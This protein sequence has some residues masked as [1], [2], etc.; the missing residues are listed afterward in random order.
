[1]ER[2]RTTGFLL[3]VVGLACLMAAGPSVAAQT[4]RTPTAVVPGTAPSAA[5]PTALTAQTSTAPQDP[6]AVSPTVVPEVTPAPALAAGESSAC[7]PLA[8]AW[9]AQLT[10]STETL[11][12]TFKF[13]PSNAEC[14]KFVVNAQAVTLSAKAIKMWPEATDLT[15][16]VGTAG[17]ASTWNDLQFTAIGYGVSRGEMGDKVVFIALLTGRIEV[18]QGC[19]PYSGQDAN[20]VTGGSSNELKMT[21]SVSYFD[22]EQDQDRDGFPDC[23]CSEAVLCVCYEAKLK[24][25]QQLEPCTASQSFFACLEKCQDVNS[26]AQG[27]AFVRILEKEQKICFLVTG[28][29]LQ[30][31]TKVVLQ[32]EG[33]DVVILLPFPPQTT[34]KEGPCEGL[35]CSGC[36]SV[37]DCAGTWKSKKFAEIEKAIQEGK[38][39]IRVVTKNC[40][41]GELCGQLGD[42]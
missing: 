35:L 40:P 6:A 33:T 31:V 41:Q 22:G 16:F 19:A 8:G 29:N 2:T 7:S 39:S 28:R 26:P 1:M 42:P 38:A 20:D 21:I 9:V 10:S 36:F 30:D 25:V 4:A 12:Q 27:R 14:S 23:E 17:I 11:L 37:K 3:L 24:R 15:M 34:G 18:P 13:I 32:I 5:G